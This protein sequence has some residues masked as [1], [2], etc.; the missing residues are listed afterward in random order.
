MNGEKSHPDGGSNKPEQMPSKGLTLPGGAKPLDIAIIALIIALTVLAGIRIYGSRG[1]TVRL[2]IEAPTG[3]WI[4]ALDRDVVVPI[5]GPLGET[6]IEIKDGKARVASSPCPNQTCVAA[7]G[8][9]R[10]GAWN[11]CLPNEVIIRVESSGDG[12]KNEGIDAFVE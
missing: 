10:P 9:S 8:I 6:V 11:A 7:P 12:E 1:N 3:R 4:Y 2:V 5:P